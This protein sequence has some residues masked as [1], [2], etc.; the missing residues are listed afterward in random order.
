MLEFRRMNPLDKPGNYSLRRCDLHIFTA[1]AAALAT[2]PMTMVGFSGESTQ[3]SCAR[4]GMAIRKNIADKKK[5]DSVF[6][7]VASQAK[8]N[9]ILSRSPSTRTS[10]DFK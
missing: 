4:S 6:F 3:P 9:S 1:N 5:T 10:A 7:T 8:R 2:S